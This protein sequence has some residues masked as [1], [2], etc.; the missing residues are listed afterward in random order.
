MARMGRPP[1]FPTV[2]VFE[3]QLYHYEGGFFKWCKDE[4]HIPLTEWFAV[5]MNCSTDAILDYAKKDGTQNGGNYDEQQDFSRIIKRVSTRIMAELI[6][7]GLT[8]KLKHDALYIFY[9]KQHGYTDKQ[10]VDTNMTV[11][12]QMQGFDDLAN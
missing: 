4:N 8:T 1:I 5:Y 11:T 2:A 12:V 6:E 10:E 7:M 3:E 9:M